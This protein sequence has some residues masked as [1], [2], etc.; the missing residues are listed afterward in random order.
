LLHGF[1]LR[2]HA[3]AE[4]AS[5]L[6]VH[7]RVAVPSWLEVQGPWTHERALAGILATLR[8][9]TDEPAIVIGHSFG[10]GLALGLAAR[11]PE[12]V[13]RLVLSDSLAVI[14]HWRLAMTAMRGMPFL[15]LATYTA[16]VDFFASLAQHPRDLARAGWW[17]FQRDPSDEIDTVASAGIRTDVLWAERDTLLDHRDGMQLAQRL[18][19]SF[20][21]YDDDVEAGPV[22]HDWVYRH[23][24]LFVSM[25][26]RI[27]IPTVLDD[28]ATTSPA[29]VEAAP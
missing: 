4:T 23:P 25:L 14:S 1:A 26:H 24:M 18:N 15:R 11:H 16:A 20:A 22:D 21:T 7:A 9:H 27:G 8:E 12:L 3:Y 5:L 29:D 17:G 6:G 10:G 28:G 19:A 13:S 2:P